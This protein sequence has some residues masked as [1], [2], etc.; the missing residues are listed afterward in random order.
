M[1]DA[2][3]NLPMVMLCGAAAVLAISLGVRHGFGLFLTPM[4]VAN[5]WGRENF[6]FA[7]AMQNLVWGAAQPFTGMLAD[8]HGARPLIMIGAI[9]YAAGLA[10]MANAATSSGFLLG[11]GLLVGLGLSG[12]TFAIVFGAIAKVVPP[13]RRSWALGVASA[14][15]SFGQFAMLPGAMGMIDSFGWPIALTILALLAAAM[16]PL[17]MLLAVSPPT[18]VRPEPDLSPGQAIREALSH[19]GFLLLCFGFFVCGFQVVF[20]ATHLPAYLLD[21]GVGG[22]VGTMTLALIGLFNIA[23]TYWAGAW[24]GRMRKPMLLTAIYV[25]RALAIALFLILPTTAVTAYL[26]GILMGLLWLSTV[27]LTNGTVASV[28]GLKN[29]AMLG[30]VVFFFHQMGAF[31]GG[32]LGGYAYDRF[33]SYDLVWWIAIGLSLVAALANWPIRETPV[34][35]LRA[36]GTPA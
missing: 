11:A 5:G 25:G 21:K 31:L 16:A 9:L 14:V 26:F 8:R 15:G 2:R 1:T 6:A 13:E 22:A 36:P 20:I 34:A 7:I 35:R 28:F 10:V 12:T 19:G 27:P 29:F 32:W 3:S 30:G 23:G 4:T 17:A 33:G 24:G 18:S